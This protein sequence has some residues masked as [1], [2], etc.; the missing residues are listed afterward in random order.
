MTYDLNF[1]KEQPGVE[2]DMQAAYEQLSLEKDVPGLAELPVERMLARIKELY[3][4]EWTQYGDGHWE[5]T[6]D[7]LE[8]MLTPYFLRV[9]FP[10]LGR[11]DLEAMMELAREFDCPLYDPQTG[12]RF[13]VK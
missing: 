2:I 12:E 13:E 6:E 7:A 10:G 1:F 5:S 9:D 8:V 4:D 11:E 3:P